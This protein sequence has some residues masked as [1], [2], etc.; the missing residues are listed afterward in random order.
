MADARIV[1]SAVEAAQA[2]F[3]AWRDTPAVHR[4]RVMFRFKA[5]IEEHLTDLAQIITAEHGKTLADAKGSLQ[6]GLEVVEFAC[7]IPHLL[8]GEFRPRCRRGSD[9]AS[10][11]TPWR[12]R[13]NQV[14]STP[15]LVPLWMF[16]G[17][18]LREQHSS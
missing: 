16:P 11:R 7:G 2:A 17:Y 14:H 4:A 8:K 18:C 5:L 3:P 10:S 9:C 1:N 6:R 13:R 12:L 15:A